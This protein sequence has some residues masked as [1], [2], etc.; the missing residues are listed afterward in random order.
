MDKNLQQIRNFGLIKN[1]LA[2]TI[3][4][5]YGENA[6]WQLQILC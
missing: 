3:K 6:K 5:L 1:C 4:L 2:V